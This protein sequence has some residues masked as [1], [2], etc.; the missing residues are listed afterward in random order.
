MGITSVVLIH[1]DALDQIENDPNF[2]KNLSN[3]IASKRHSNERTATVSA[4]TSCNAA[5][6]V[7]R[8]FDGS[9]TQ[10]V[11]IES[12]IGWIAKGKEKPLWPQITKNMVTRAFSGLKRVRNKAN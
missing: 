11:V 5:G 7:G 12:G 1:H 6:V 4:G 8:D 9:D 3:A 2:G 10:F